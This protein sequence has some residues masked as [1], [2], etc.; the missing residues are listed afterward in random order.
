MRL[1]RRGLE[2]AHM[3]RAMVTV[4]MWYADDIDLSKIQFLPGL[5]DTISQLN[6]Q[7]HDLFHQLYSSKYDCMRLNLLL[8]FVL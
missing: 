1:D 2:V 6:S 4:A 7:Y 5:D 3:R 8:N